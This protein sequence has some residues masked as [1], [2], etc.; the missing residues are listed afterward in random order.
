MANKVEIL[1]EVDPNGRGAAAIRNVGVNIDALGK[2]TRDAGAAGRDALDGFAGGLGVPTSIAAASAATAAGILLIGNAAKNASLEAANAQRI[3]RSD[4]QTAGIEFAAAQA[5]ARKFGED[6]AISNTQA[7]V[8]FARFLRVVKAAGL[9]ENLADY[10]K[11]FADLAA[12]YGL[13]ATEVETLTSQLLS[14]QDE[15]LNRLGIAD[16]SQLYNRYAASVGKTVEQLTEEEKVRAR[17]LAVIEKG[18]Q[19]EGVAAQRLTEQTGQWALLSKAISDATTNLGDFLTKRTV[20][21]D[22][23]GLIT[24]LSKGENPIT[25]LQDRL[26]KDAAAKAAAARAKAEKDLD[27]YFQRLGAN[28]T[29]EARANPF[30]SF[31]NRVSILGKE[32]AEK[33]RENFVRQFESIFKDKRL[34]TTTAIFAEEQF[35]NIRGILS[36]DKAAQIEEDF[37]KFFNK[38]AKVALGALKTAR[39][40][41]ED[42]L[43]IMADRATGG[44]NPYVKIL[45]D[46]DER[47]KELQKTFGILGDKVVQEMQRAE[48]AYTQQKLLALDLDQALKTAALRREADALANFSGVTA[49]EPRRLSIADKQIEAA[50]SVPQLLARAEAIAKGIVRLQEGQLDEAGNRVNPNEALRF[51]L[52]LDQAKINK[53]IF[54]ALTRIDTGGGQR[55]EDR[56]NQALVDF[57]TSLPPEVQARIA[58][59][60]EGGAQQRAFA[61]AFRG[62]ADAQRR[63]IDEEI[64]KA[65][66]A[67]Q[68]V[69]SIAEDIAKIEEARRA[70]L[71]AREADA[72]LLATTGELSPGEMTADIRQARIEALRREA[73]ATAQAQEEAKKA[74]ENS[75][76]ATTKLTSSIDA[77]A[78]S[79]RDPK[80]RRVLIDI[81]N[82]A[83]GDVRSELYGDLQ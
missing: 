53:E 79:L 70:G 8:S 50:S 38:Y 37:T 35:R 2:K 49:A 65:R 52:G 10:R 58:S 74:V 51:E 3:L 69:Q 80:N 66:V 19:F 71:S 17:L 55:V 5:E 22:I 46:A 81:N 26:D 13:T 12:A 42:N 15:A 64:A 31:E 18:E 28:V 33:E 16:P 72:R 44:N 4:A 75:T 32:G 73:D 29:P 25:A 77:L 20:L 11:R 23:P 21:A 45:L 83:K 59:G 78:V 82:R 24:S 61:D 36:P 27:S 14:G 47:A 68:A 30:G 57:F 60:Q 6:L 63:A 7:E 41:A 54:D 67:D 43:D 34:D 1:V 9:T 62:S 48:E 39:D 40:A 56:V 76:E